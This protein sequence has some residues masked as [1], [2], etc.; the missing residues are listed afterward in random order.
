[1]MNEAPRGMGAGVG[2]SAGALLRAA[3]EKQGLHI[4]ALAASIKVAPR[5]LEAL[6]NDR[7]DQLPGATFVRA[8]AQTVCRSLRIDPLPVLA[9]LPR[10][11]AAELDQVGGTLNAPFRDRSS[12]VGAGLAAVAPAPL[13]WA[14]LALLLA[15]VLTYFVPAAWYTPG[16]PPPR[17]QVVAPAAPVAAALPSQVVPAASAV[18]QLVASVPGVAPAVEAQ[19]A[20]AAVAAASAPQVE[21]TYTTPSAQAQS[22]APAVAGMLQLSTTESSWVEVRDAGGR[23][24]FSRTVLPGEAVGLDGA[25]PMRLTVGNVAVTQATFRGQAVDLAATARDKVARVELK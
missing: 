5:K 7:Y 20:P 17:P 8:L 3:R 18:A 14:G 4:A 10:A 22:S 25:L 2:A 19:N 16:D 1:M 23:I 6:E 24:L 12:R 15:A 21:I 9:L 11:D 13:V